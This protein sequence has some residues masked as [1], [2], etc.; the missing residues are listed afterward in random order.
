MLGEA[1]WL[2]SSNIKNEGFYNSHGFRSVKDMEFGD[3]EK[4][5]IVQLVS[6]L[7]ACLDFD[8]NTHHNSDGSR[9]Q[10]LGNGEAH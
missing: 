4:P 3:A 2:V 10:S 6:S 5:I 9:A 8:P 1:C 7:L